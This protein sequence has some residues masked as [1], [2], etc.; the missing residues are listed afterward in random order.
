MAKPVKSLLDKVWTKVL[1]SVIVP[2]LPRRRANL[3][4]CSKKGLWDPYFPAAQNV[5]SQ[6]WDEIIWA[7]IKDFDFDAVLELAPGAGRNTAMLCRV[8]KKIY[9][10]D[11]NSYALK[12]CRDKFGLSH[13]GCD[14]EYHVN[15]GADLEMI[16]GGAVSAVYC[17]DAAVHFDKSV[18]EGY[19]REFARVLR[20]GGRGFIHHSDL[21]EEANKNIKKN[22]H[23]R[24]NVSRESFAQMCRDNDL[25]VVTQ[26]DIPWSDIVDCGTIFEKP[27]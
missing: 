9:A 18:M 3:L 26:A 11:Y 25:R 12:Q 22:P 2:L 7:L 21:G 8:A 20:P 13:D 14:I 27:P 10:V 4:Q 19:V 5:M 16:P 15:N 6:Q 23:W 24:S 17:W 1:D